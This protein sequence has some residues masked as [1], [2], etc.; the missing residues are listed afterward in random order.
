M[1]NYY[2]LE[3][4][5]KAKKIGETPIMTE[6]TVFP[7]IL[8]EHM[9][10]KGKWAKVIVVEGELNYKW[11]DDTKIYTIDKD[12]SL[13]IEPER[14]HNVILVGEVQFKIEFY[15]IENSEKTE[16]NKEALRPGENFI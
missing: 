7:Q 12:N 16:Y 6:N 8:E 2:K 10:P 5:Q 1:K 15:K 9:T 11:H 4:A 13:V 3:L 14:T